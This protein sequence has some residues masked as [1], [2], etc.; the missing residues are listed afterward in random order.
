[1]PSLEH[2]AEALVRDSEQACGARHAAFGVLK[3]QLDEACFIAQDLFLERAAR[4]GIAKRGLICLS[5]RDDL[6]GF[7]RNLRSFGSRQDRSLD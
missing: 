6:N 7:P 5:G 4:P 2:R 1:M 3:G